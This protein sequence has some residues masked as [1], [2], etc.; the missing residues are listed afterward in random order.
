MSNS[1]D[2]LLWRGDL[3][4]SADGF[5]EVDGVI[6]SVLAYIDLGEI[7]VEDNRLYNMMREYLPD[8][9]YDSQ[10]MGLVIPSKNINRIFCLAASTRRFSSIKVTDYEAYTSVEDMCQYAAVVFHLSNGESVIAFRGTDDTLVGW[11]EDCA[12]SYLDEIP[13]QRLALSYFKRMCEKY[14][15]RKFYIVG[16]SKGGNLAAYSFAMAPDA[17]KERV[18]RIYSYDGPG[19]RPALADKMRESQ[20]RDRF[21]FILPQSSFIGTMFDKCNDYT[22]VKSV[23]R[24]STQHDAFGWDVKGKSFVK[25]SSLSAIGKRNEE[26]F[27]QSIRDM[28]DEEKKE[29]IDTLFTVIE[30]TGATNLSE[31]ADGKLKAVATLMKN[32][33]SVEKSRR[34]LVLG[35]VTRLFDFRGQGEA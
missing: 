34:E 35:F 26:Q 20:Y 18:V 31:L 23:S 19:L 5:N 30:S 22:V 14:P 28:T 7:S 17:L 21:V 2:Y 12:L 25:M 3:S 15:D 1:F 33:G 13:A 16:H 10:R 8:R 29:V 6:L 4:F 11:R 9:K 32:Y 24:G 27:R